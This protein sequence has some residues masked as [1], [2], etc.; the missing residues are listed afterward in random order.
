M[1]IKDIEDHNT[2]LLI[3][4][5]V[6]KTGIQRSFTVVGEFYNICK[7]YMNLRPNDSKTDRFFLN[8]QNEKCTR[9]AIGINKFGGLP[10]QIATYLNLPEPE[11]YT[12]HSFRRTSATLLVDNG[13]DITA[14]KRHGGW[15]SNTVAEGYIENSINNKTKIGQQITSSLHLIPSNSTG[16]SDT[17]E[18]APKH[19]KLSHQ[20]DVRPSTSTSSSSNIQANE[21]VSLQFNNCSVTIQMFE[22]K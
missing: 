13:G 14:L 9:Q 20:E 21:N 22:N 7:K 6:S 5:P 4:I 10:K 11:L 2:M 19:F 16:Q 1:T 8:F 3:K 12:G 15:K 18:P 17:D